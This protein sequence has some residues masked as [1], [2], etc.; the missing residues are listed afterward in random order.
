[1]VARSTLAVVIQAC[2]VL[3]VR[4][5]GKPDEKPRK[6]SVAIFGWPKI[7][8]GEVRVVVGSVTAFPPTV[9]VVAPLYAWRCFLWSRAGA[10]AR[11]L[12]ASRLLRPRRTESAHRSGVHSPISDD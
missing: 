11:P 1:M 7:R 4:Y 9:S 2:S 12:S 3:L 6:S 10:P 5:N 8:S